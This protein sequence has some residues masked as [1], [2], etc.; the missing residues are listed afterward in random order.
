MRQLVAPIA[1]LLAAACGMAAC[2]P[3]EPERQAPSR[4]ASVENEAR[5]AADGFCE[6]QWPAAAPGARKYT[7]IPERPLPGAPAV[8]AT[9]GGSWKWVNLWATWCVPCVEEMRLLAR[10]R[11]ALAKDGITV[12]LELWSVDAEEGKL[13]EY[14][15]KTPMPGR[16]RWLRAQDDLPGALESLGTDRTAGIPV[17]AL[18]D[19]QGNLR[20][21]RVG[22][23][24]DEDYGAVKSMLSAS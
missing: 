19:G 2:E 9:K 20:C 24:H 5:R 14:L 12:D 3:A 10:W 17:H 13:M 11:Q 18:V 7:G 8:A 4:F 15:E 22:S 21:V 6:K 16:V 1:C 23:V